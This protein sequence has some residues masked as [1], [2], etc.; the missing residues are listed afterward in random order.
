VL[1]GTDAD[2]AEELLE[3]LVDAVLVD[4]AGV[5]ATGLIRYRLHDLLRDFARECLAED[6][7]PGVREESLGTLADQ[8]IGA[9]RPTRR[10]PP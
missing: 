1:T 4:C 6:E 10:R 5:D 9:A 8:Y 7:P 2:G 3:H